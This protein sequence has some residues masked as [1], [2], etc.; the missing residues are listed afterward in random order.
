MFVVLGRLGD[1][2]LIE[3]DKRENPPFD[4][5]NKRN[6]ANLKVDKLG[7]SLDIHFSLPSSQI[8]HCL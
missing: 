2:T 3:D 5:L 1:E 6:S 8:D 7:Q 4:S